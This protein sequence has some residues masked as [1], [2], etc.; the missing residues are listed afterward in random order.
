MPSELPDGGLLGHRSPGYV[1]VEPL[2]ATE[3]SAS[4][5]APIEARRRPARWTPAGGTS[6]AAS[7]PG[8]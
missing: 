4:H 7:I 2:D 6:W 1:P 5:G 8:T 3:R